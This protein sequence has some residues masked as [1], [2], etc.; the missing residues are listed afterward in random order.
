[1][2]YELKEVVLEPELAATRIRDPLFL[3]FRADVREVVKLY[4]T[5]SRAQLWSLCLHHNLTRFRNETRWRQ[6][7]ALKLHVCNVGCGRTVYVFRILARPR[8]V[9][10]DFDYDVELP[11]Q[12]VVR[13]VVGQ[14]VDPYSE[15]LLQPDF[16]DNGIS[17]GTPTLQYL[18]VAGDVLK[19]D[20]IKEWQSEM[21]TEKLRLKT[22]AVCATRTCAVDVHDCDA[23][24]IDLT[25]LRND[26][27]PP[28]S[29]P[30]SYN[31]QAYDRAILCSAG[32]SNSNVPSVVQVCTECQK[33][34]LHGGMPK[35]ALANWLYYGREALPHDVREAFDTAS[36]FECMLISRVRYNSVSCRFKASQYDPT[37]DET[38][39][40]YVLRNY[41]KGV[42]GNVVVTPLDVARLQ[43]VL[44]PPP[45]V[46][47]DT[48][49]VIFIGSVPPSR[50][51]IR[52]LRPVLVRKSKVKLM[53]EFLIAHNPHY[54]RLAGFRGIDENN[55]NRLFDSV[56]AG[57]D[58][59]FLGSVHI[60][61]LPSDD[62]V[63]SATADY[64]PRNVDGPVGQASGH[65]VLMENVG[66]T[67][68]DHSASSYRDMKYAALER[69]LAGKP[70][71]GYR[72][73][74][75]MVPDFDNP[76]L[77][78]LA[79]P[80]EDPWGIGGFNHPLRTYRISEQMQLSHM[81]T[82]HGGRFQRHPQFAFFYYNVIRKKLV[83]RSMRYRTKNPN[84][85]SVI[86]RM[87][88]LD[89]SQLSALRER[90]KRDLLYV[91]ATET[92]K[93]MM[94][95][96][97]SVGLIADQ[98]PGSIGHKVSL[99]NQIRG[100]ITYRGAPTLFITLNP[101]DVDNPIVR[102]L[103]GDD[104]VLEDLARGEDMDEWS[105]KI[106]AA[107]NPAPCAQF[108]DLVMTKFISIILRFGRP[109]RGLFG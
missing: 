57:L 94:T 75:K 51:T 93:R 72:S 19:S 43:D 3:V 12:R 76:Y 100:L 21:S 8:Q 64:T 29:L 63:E 24:A 90:C 92:E 80:E 16:P 36:I 71:L 7:D 106:L 32:L 41:R 73:G 49:S 89:L 35:L 85:K 58:E 95:L 15:E 52:R 96:M 39:D 47:R 81:L 70:F 68:G 13:N 108:F 31:F 86:D 101:S 30:T 109:G 69:C 67:A 104:I 34:V 48:M 17:D 55:L 2:N 45:E 53:L 77:L 11:P 102:L 4:R 40:T 59:S 33:K 88:E 78:S 87:L 105:R 38:E 50:H 84:Y 14:G 1:M 61:H 18:D 28:A 98:I 99:R 66:F 23:S 97:G 74:S 20:I 26:R 5:L 62:A 10:P 42:R 6:R 27:L 25:L 65:D 83:S 54:G 9:D 79:F 107:K 103:A 82:M 60:G 22:C 46:I 91:P 44:P 56:D 37:A